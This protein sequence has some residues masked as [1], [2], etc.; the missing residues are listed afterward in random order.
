MLDC[1]IIAWPECQCYMGQLIE[2]VCLH[3]FEQRRCVCCQQNCLKPAAMPSI[4][5]EV[6][7]FGTGGGKFLPNIHPLITSRVSMAFPEI[8]NACR[9]W[10]PLDGLK[11]CSAP[12]GQ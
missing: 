1:R 2:V 6:K 10:V 4:A 11:L 5:T 8:Y 7:F 3:D 9:T 12:A